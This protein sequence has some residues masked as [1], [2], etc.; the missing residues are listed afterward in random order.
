MSYL[1]H[2]KIVLSL[3]VVL[4]TF[5]A[6]LQT[7]AMFHRQEPAGPSAPRA[8]TQIRIEPL[9]F[10]EDVVILPLTQPEDAEAPDMAQSII[11]VL[12]HHTTAHHRLF[13]RK[14]YDFLRPHDSAIPSSAV[15]NTYKFKDDEAT[16]EG[17]KTY[18]RTKL[19]KLTPTRAW[20]FVQY[21]QEA[22]NKTV[23]ENAK[24]A[25][26]T[27][28]ANVFTPPQFE[29][30]EPLWT[31]L[32]DIEKAYRELQ[33]NCT[34]ILLENV[35]GKSE[36]ELRSWVQALTQTQ[37]ALAEKGQQIPGVP[38]VMIQQLAAAAHIE[39]GSGTDAPEDIPA[40]Q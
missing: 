39:V 20:E 31:R 7:N 30:L 9:P 36:S 35:T 2:K 16:F 24:T 21:F 6:T 4:A 26:R 40:K 10:A 18:I 11:G 27:A 38:P 32:L 25:R 19:S 5:F 3:S 33:Q 34:Q 23:T 37:L 13:L 15:V 29:R 12:T 22:W 8:R 28:L 17:S 1:S 14:C